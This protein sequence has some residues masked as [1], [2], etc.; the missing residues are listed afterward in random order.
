MIRLALAVLLVAALLAVAMP[1]VENGAAAK[2]EGTVKQAVADIESAALSLLN[3]ERL[4][5][6][7]ITGPQ[8]TVTVTFP[9]KG[10]TSMPVENLTIDRI[11][12]RNVSSVYFRVQGNGKKQRLVDAPIVNPQRDRVELGGTTGEV[13]LVLLLQRD[14]DTGEPIVVLRKTSRR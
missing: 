4:P 9:T 14:A 5:P 8:R 13:T 12:D 10:Y 7:G 2:S 3:E 1:A 6:K 11:P